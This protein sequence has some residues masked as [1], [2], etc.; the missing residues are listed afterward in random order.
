MLAFA[1]SWRSI[2]KQRGE[3]KACKSSRMNFH[4]SHDVDVFCECMW[5]KTKTK[6]VYVPENL[7]KQRNDDYASMFMPMRGG[8]RII[9]WKFLR[10]KALLVSIAHP[11]IRFIEVSFFHHPAVG[12]K[13]RRFR[14][15]NYGNEIIIYSRVVIAQLC[16]V[17]ISDKINER[18]LLLFLIRPRAPGMLFSNSNSRFALRLLV[19]NFY[20][21]INELLGRRLSEKEQQQWD[22]EKFTVW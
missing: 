19:T 21:I 13:R 11:S 14:T 2:W 8:K 12:S 4:P 9:W 17:S 18:S 3:Q 5:W 1:F 16:I 6:L 22:G 20:Y 10:R 15:I 7:T